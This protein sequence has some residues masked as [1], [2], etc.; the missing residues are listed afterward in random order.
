M[1]THTWTSDGPSG[2]YKN[3][4]I[5]SRL[6]FASIANTKFMQFIRDVEDYGRNRGESITLTRVSNISE[7]S[8]GKLTEGVRISEDTMSLSTKQITVSEYGRAVPYTSLSD[9]LSEY[10]IANVVQRKLMEQMRLTLDTAAAAAFTSSSVKIKAIPDGAA[11]VTFDTDG[12]ASTPATHNWSVFLV[13]EIRD[14]LFST[15]FA[16]PFMGDDYVTLIATKGKRGIVSDPGWEKWHQYTDPSNKFNSEIGRIENTRFVEVN[17]ANA[18]SGSLGSSSQLGEGVT[19][20]MDPVV[21][22]VAL[23]PELRAKEEDFGRYKA[24]AWYAILE[25][26]EVWDTANAGEANIVHVTSS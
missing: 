25:F 13:E 26:G 21:M 9:D 2:V 15:L 6:R 20:G 5:S 24:V 22:A 3:H 7:P 18:L 4:A 1:A 23:D 12:T 8:S 14:Y 11:S 16:E 17:H 10:N 19:F